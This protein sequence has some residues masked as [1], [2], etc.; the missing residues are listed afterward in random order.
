MDFEIRYT[1]EQEAFRGEVRA[2]LAEHVPP[3]INKTPESP[4]EAERLYQARRVLGREL[5]ARGW[6][7]PMAPK[8]Y[9][10]GGMDLDRALVLFEEADRIGIALPPF[11]D[12]GGILG[13]GTILVW[14]TEEQK[15]AFL[16]PIYRGE[17]RAWQLLSE[18]SAGSDLANVKTRAVREGDHYVVTGQKIFVG[19]DHGAEGLFTL[20]CTDPDR[21]RHE[22]L[23]WFWIDGRSPGITIQPMDLWGGSS[24]GGQQVGR[25]NIVFFDHVRVPAFN[26]IGGENNG[27]RVASTHLEL[28]HGFGFVRVLG[29]RARRLWQQIY[30][31]GCTTV[32]DGRPLV[33]DPA[34]RD[35]LAEIYIRLEI[36]RLLE[37]RNFWLV[38][39]RQPRSYEGA[40]A[41]Y[42]RKMTGLWLTQAIAEIVGPFAFTNDPVWGAA[43]G[44]L[45]LQQR[46][47]VCD[48]HPGGTADIQKVVMARRIGIGRAEP[49][50]A[51]AL[52]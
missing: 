51:G 25:K 47:G 22:N 43:E 9:G 19:S 24:E 31:Y 40:Q 49:E 27:W 36:Q 35:R 45:E 44:Y 32:R 5:G 14:G 16:P 34:V 1:P 42:V 23:S 33:S 28:E 46:D 21:P 3:D 26:L 6:L 12:T 11:Y 48:V 52:A 20:T 38:S 39:A 50:Q 4:E 17:V 2:W 10:G 13:S 8:E 18:P 29:T 37:T 15:R 30:D 41:S 7:F